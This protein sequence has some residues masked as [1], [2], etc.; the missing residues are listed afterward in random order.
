MHARPNPPIRQALFRFRAI[1]RCSLTHPGKQLLWADAV[2]RWEWDVGCGMEDGRRKT[3]D[4][5]REREEIHGGGSGSCGAVRSPQSAVRGF[6]TDALVR[7]TLNV[8]RLNPCPL[9][10][11]THILQHALDN[12]WA[13]N[14]HPRLI[15]VIPDRSIAHTRAWIRVVFRHENLVVGSNMQALIRG[16]VSLTI[17]LPPG[18][19]LPSRRRSTSA[20]ACHSKY[21]ANT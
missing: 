12:G 19:R 9:T 8:D 4:G 11:A 16:Y 18:Q 6:H 15:C 14:A 10:T 2:E 1:P 21:T 3:E 20:R 7:A 5:K 17:S 13:N